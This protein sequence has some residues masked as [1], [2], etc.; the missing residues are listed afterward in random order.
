MSY[1]IRKDASQ[2]DRVIKDLVSEKAAKDN[3]S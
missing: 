2:Q 3:V 1:V